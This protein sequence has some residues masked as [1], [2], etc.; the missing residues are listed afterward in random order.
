MLTDPSV[1]SLSLG[2]IAP[3]YTSAEG[4]GIAVHTN[5]IIK[6]VRSR[7]PSWLQKIQLK[8]LF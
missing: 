4:S 7:D 8:C 1:T 5:G 6:Q 3:V 2:S